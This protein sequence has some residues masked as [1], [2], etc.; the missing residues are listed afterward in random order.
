MNLFRGGGQPIK[1]IR[2]ILMPEKR[3]RCL[4]KITSLDYI[5]EIGFWLFFESR[6]SELITDKPKSF[7]KNM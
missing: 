1:N 7:L 6:F 3:K 5:F 2:I 4:H